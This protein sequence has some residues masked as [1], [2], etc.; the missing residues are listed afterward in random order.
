MNTILVWLEHTAAADPNRAAFEDPMGSITWGAL[1][2]QAEGIGTTLAGI[3][4]ANR[5]VA[6]FMEKSVAAVIGMMG[7]VYARGF[8]SFIDLRQPK[9]RLQ[10]V[11]TKL[12]PAVIFADHE[13]LETARELFA[14]QY[15]VIDLEELEEQRPKA[16]PAVLSRI[17]STC[18]DTDP[19]YVNFTSGSTGIPKG[20]VVCHRSV[21]DFIPIFDKTFGITRDD[22]MGNQAP[23]DFD[24]SVKDI[25]SGLYTGARTVLIP[26]SYFVN[27]TALMDYLA[28]HAVTTLVWAVS[29]M[30]FVS[31][32]NGFSYRTPESVNKVLFSGEVMPVKQLN[33]WR[34]YLPDAAY[35]NLYG[36]TEITCNCTYFV[37]DPAKTYALDEVIPAGKPF[38]NEKVFLLDEQDQEVTGEG[39]VG[40]IC[41]GGT[42][43]AAGYYREREKTEAVFVQNPLNEAWPERIYRT[44]DLGKYDAQGNL[45]YV[46]RKDFQIKHLGH[47]IELGEIETDAMACDGVTRACC[48]YD[49]E[50]KKLVLFYTGDRDKKELEKDLRTRLPDFMVPNRTIQIDR[51]PLN[52]NGKIDRHALMDQ[53]HGGK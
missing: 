11:I 27:P 4:V 48:I 36:P 41:V 13:N 21:I 43:V 18:L 42:C 5:P 30:C 51:M 6:F 12:D 33:I 23:F 16:D 45:I 1:R 52:K 47:R 14:P 50:K 19:L 38:P 40:E 53:Y 17:R 24:V 28:D 8:Y 35:V 2:E 29:A 32:M 37:L 25:Y 26:R 49:S 15:R 10:T 44:G 22:V 9:T 20:V 39:E 7:T 46:S 3:G 34:K 31:I